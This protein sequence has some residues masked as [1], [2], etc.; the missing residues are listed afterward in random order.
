MAAAT[1]FFAFMLGVGVALVLILPALLRN[2]GTL[3]DE[4]LKT[5]QDNVTAARERKRALRNAVDNGELTEEEAEEYAVEI[6]NTLL[7]DI[8]TPEVAAPTQQRDRAGAGIVVAVLLLLTPALYFIVGE[9][10]ALRQTSQ[11]TA[12][13]TNL[14]DDENESALDMKSLA[15]RLHKR[16]DDLPNDVEALYWLGRVYAAQQEHKTA[17]SYYERAHLLNPDFPDL[18]A[19]Y[20]D[21][22]ITDNVTNNQGKI[23]ALLGNGLQASPN[24][25]TLL[26]LAG[27]NAEYNGQL[28][29]A[30]NFW[31]RAHDNLGDSPES[32]RQIAIIIADAKSRQNAKTIDTVSN[33]SEVTVVV[34]IGKTINIPQNAIL[35]V[36]AKAAGEGASAVP[37][38]V[39]RQT[40]ENFSFPLTVRL[41]DSMA[42][43]PAIKMSN[44]SRYDIYAQLSKNGNAKTQ[45]GDIIGI[46][47]DI[48]PQNTVTVLIEQVVK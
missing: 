46:A 11:A 40:A 48:L 12:F 34:N 17:L 22:L 41:N 3:S 20:T 45:A 5:R 42:M 30:L 19:A 29:K 35:F 2:N 32:Q 33:N 25:P 18:T 24:H 15:A 1:I 8:D 39:F 14:S 6:E 44:F 43:L 26:W 13:N 47:S 37:L 36:Y 10:Q 4:Q 27:I 16:L 38:A 23:N 9:P 7:Q 31:Q 21:A 28:E